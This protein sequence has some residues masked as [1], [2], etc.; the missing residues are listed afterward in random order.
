VSQKHEVKIRRLRRSEEV[1]R[2][3]SEF[4]ASGV[5][6]SKFCREHRLARSVLYR[7]LPRGGLGKMGP[8]PSGRLIPVSLLDTEDSEKSGSGSALELVLRHGRR[9]EV[10]PNFDAATLER[11]LKILEGV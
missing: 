7:H 10:R 2:L 3:V 6:A 11:L 9:I 5:E 1:K 8:K 4:A